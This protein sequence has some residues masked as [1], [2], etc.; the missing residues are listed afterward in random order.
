LAVT[1]SDDGFREIQL[2]GKQLVFLFMAVT[3]VLVVTFL[4]GVLVGRGVRAERA[5]AAQAEAVTEAPPLPARAPESTATADGD[6]PTKASAP[7]VDLGETSEPPVAAPRTQVEAKEVPAPAPVESTRTVEAAKKDA[8]REAPKT[9]SAPPA[10]AAVETAKNTSTPAPGAASAVPSGPPS[11]P[12]N[13]YAVQVAAV[14]AR[15]DADAIV[16]RLSAKGYPAY[17]EVPKNTA[18]V[19]RVRVGTFRTRRE[20][21][22]MA[23]RLKKEEKFKPWVTR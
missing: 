6:D 16:R 14:N 15:G 4:T 22:S 3:V 9:A 19:F 1:S 11:G 18:S 13:G 12:R 7:P 5:E 8:P 20:A 2:N 10:K 23:D 17:V 21:Q